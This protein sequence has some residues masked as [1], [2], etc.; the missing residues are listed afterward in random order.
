[1]Q[2]FYENFCEVLK[3]NKD[4]FIALEVNIHYL[5]SNY[6][7]TGAATLCVSGLIL[8]PPT[9][10]IS[11]CTWLV[12]V[13]Y[14][15]LYLG[16]YVACDNF[17]F[18]EVIVLESVTYDSSISCCYFESDEQNNA[19]FNTYLKTFILEGHVV[20]A[21]MFVVIYFYLLPFLSLWKTVW[22]PAFI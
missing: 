9:N 19:K 6:S 16:W 11:L 2:S 10:S 22:K 17:F 8:A 13:N 18:Q 3:D 7:H 12:V 15:F 20:S 5:G 21:N 4:G 1:M 14:K